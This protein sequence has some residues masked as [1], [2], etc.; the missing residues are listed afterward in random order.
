LFRSASTPDFRRAFRRYLAVLFPCWFV[1]LGVGLYLT[2]SRRR[3]ET[4][5][6][7]AGFALVGF[8]IIPAISKLVGCSRCELK[9]QCPWMANAPTCRH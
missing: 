2:C 4:L 7:T 9:D 3:R 5:Y 1:P 6:L 8:V